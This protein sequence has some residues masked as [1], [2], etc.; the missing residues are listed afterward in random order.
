MK[1]DTGNCRGL[2][3]QQR[4]EDTSLNTFHQRQSSCWPLRRAIQKLAVTLATD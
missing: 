2:K 3:M 1:E 4:T